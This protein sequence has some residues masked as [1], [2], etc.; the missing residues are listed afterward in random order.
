MGMQSSAGGAHSHKGE[1][2]KQERERDQVAGVVR[3]GEIMHK[4][5]T[6]LKS[7]S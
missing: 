4:G 5:L 1:R 6:H 2:L 3:R 7:T